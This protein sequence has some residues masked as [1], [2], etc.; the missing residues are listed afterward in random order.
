MC[1]HKIALREGRDPHLLLVGVPLQGSF[2]EGALD[3]GVA[4]IAT[5]APVQPQQRIVAQHIPLAPLPSWRPPRN[6]T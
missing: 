1:T 3:G 5:P 4:H 6:T 2:P